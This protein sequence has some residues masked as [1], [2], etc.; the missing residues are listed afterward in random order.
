VVMTN[1]TLMGPVR[2]LREMFDAMA[3]QQ[4][5][6]FWGLS[7]HHGAK[8]NPFKGKHLYRY[9][10]VHI[11]SHFIVYRKRFIQSPELQAYWNEMPMI[12]SYTDSVQ[13]YEAVFTKQFEDR[14]F[15][16]DVYVK[17]DDLKEFTDYPLLVCPVRLLRDKKCLLFKRRSFIHTSEEHTSDLQ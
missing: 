7:I 9:L 6:D 15:K 14:G 11:Q 5:L 8:T 4:D 3:E 2:P 13:R 17:T 1:S 16:W 10:P 12:E